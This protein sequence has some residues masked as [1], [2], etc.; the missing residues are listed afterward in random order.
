MRPAREGRENSPR[1]K[2]GVHVDHAS[3]RPAREG[4]ENLGGTPLVNGTVALQ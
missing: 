2:G 3:M 4:R 1:L